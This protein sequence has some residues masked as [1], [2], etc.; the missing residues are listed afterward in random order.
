MPLMRLKKV[1]LPAPFGPMIGAQFALLHRQRYV[2]HRDQAAESLAD[3][4][5]LE[6][7]S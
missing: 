7:R 3:L 1:V 6:Q 2:A 4:P 5:D